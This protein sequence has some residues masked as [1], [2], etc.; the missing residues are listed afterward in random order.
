MANVTDLDWVG[1]RSKRH[2][3]DVLYAL[4]SCFRNPQ[5]LQVM[6]TGKGWNGYAESRRLEYMGKPVGLVAFG[7]VAMKGWCQTN[8][9]GDAMDLITG[10]TGETLT[11]LVE[12]LEGQFKRVDI[13]RTTFD[14]SVSVETVRRA[15]SE[16]GFSNG[17]R[18]PKMRSI[19]SSCDTDGETLYI[20]QRDQP[21]FCRAYEKGW[22]L[23]KSFGAA[24][25]ARGLDVHS[26]LR[27]IRIDDAPA[28][29]IFR[30]EVE[31]KP[32]PELFPSDILMN[33]DT[34]FA[35]AYPYLASLVQ[36]DSQPFR[37]TA[38]RKAS[39]T[40]DQALAQVRRQ[41]GDVLYTALMLHHGDMTA[42]WDKIIGKKHS[43][44]LIEA[45]VLLA[46]EAVH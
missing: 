8:L 40:M 21:K 33:R 16:G 22:E 38:E 24:L 41:Y 46:M 3:A 25:D 30:V 11:Q 45:G 37:L 18:N 26:Y 32:A 5:Y 28:A 15:Y 43:Q 17:G 13:A 2:F 4:P 44:T 27:D 12:D 14:G 39:A 7:G 36:S 23:V 10:D 42:V 34:Y 31:F 29:D 1:F 19:K 6:G 9:T 35:G 20:G